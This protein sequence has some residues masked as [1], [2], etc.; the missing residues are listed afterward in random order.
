MKITIDLPEW[1]DERHVWV[2]AGQEPVYCRLRYV[3]KEG[4]VTYKEFKKKIR[5]NLCGKCCMN[6]RPDWIWGVDDKG[7]CLRLTKGN[8]G[9]FY[10]DIR[11][12]GMPW[13][14][15]KG[16]N[17]SSEFCVLEYEEI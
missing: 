16:D 5:C 1:T 10:C 17:R 6:L 12:G 9:K 2:I 3:D 15:L 4:N 8:P 14:C 11:K 7:T 13:D